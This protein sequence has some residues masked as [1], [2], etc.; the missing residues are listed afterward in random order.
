MPVLDGALYTSCIEVLGNARDHISFQQLVEKLQQEPILGLEND[1]VIYYY[2]HDYGIGLIYKKYRQSFGGAVFLVDSPNVKRGEMQRYKGG[3]QTN[4]TPD[5]SML[6]I[7]S[8]IPLVPIGRYQD[9]NGSGLYYKF[10]D[11]QVTFH[12]D[13]PGQ[14][15][16]LALV[17]LKQPS[18]KETHVG[19]ASTLSL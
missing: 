3:F 16:Q 9:S 1:H 7:E 5:D 8:K 11:H 18:K 14:H 6:Q 4:V 17:Q 15:L 19:A 2:F 12:F 13:G 10:Q